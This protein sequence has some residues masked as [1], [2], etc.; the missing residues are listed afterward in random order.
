LGRSIEA[1]SKIGTAQVLG[2]IAC[3]GVD[4]DCFDSQRPE[5]EMDRIAS[6]GVIEI[7]F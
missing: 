4:F 3:G 7:E 5:F 6:P 2:A 1:A